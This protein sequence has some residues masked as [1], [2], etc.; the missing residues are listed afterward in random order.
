MNKYIISLTY[1]DGRSETIC[2][3]LMSEH[4]MWVL[5]NIVKNSFSQESYGVLDVTDKW[6]GFNLF[7]LSELRYARFYKEKEND[8]DKQED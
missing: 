2:T 3:N 6:G 7:R 8:L 5:F 1:K 4:E